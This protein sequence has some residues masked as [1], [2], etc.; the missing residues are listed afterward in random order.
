M[1]FCEDADKCKYAEGCRKS[2]FCQIIDGVRGQARNQHGQLFIFTCKKDAQRFK[3]SKKLFG[4]HRIVPIHINYIDKEQ[5]NG[6]T[7]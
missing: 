3:K 6:V 2:N 7:N 1:S 4:K 5:L